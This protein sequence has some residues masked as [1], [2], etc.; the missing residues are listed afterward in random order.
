ME[1][2]VDL[3]LRWEFQMVGSVRN[4]CSDKEQSVAFGG[5]FG[6]RVCGGE[7]FGIQSDSVSH[8]VRHEACGFLDHQIL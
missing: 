4:G 5:Q 6:S 1:D 3:P 7:I 2:V 8:A